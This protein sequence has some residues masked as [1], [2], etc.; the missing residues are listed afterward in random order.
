GGVSRLTRLVGAHWAKYVIMANKPVDAQRALMIGLV[1]EV[2]PDESFDEDCLAF[3][4]HLAG[5]KPEV[6][7][8]AKIAIDIAQDLEAEQAR[9][10]ERIANSALM[11]GKEYLD[12]FKAMQEK[13]SRNTGMRKK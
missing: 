1:H 11:I 10:M 9:N 6:T 3:C 12:S 2:F 7:G 5:L 8:M 4:R 13:L